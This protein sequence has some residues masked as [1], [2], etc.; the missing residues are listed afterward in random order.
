[1]TLWIFCLAAHS[2]FSS[3]PAIEPA[4]GAGGERLGQPLI[5]LLVKAKSNR[6]ERAT[7]VG[8]LPGATDGSGRVPCTS[9]GAPSEQGADG[10]GGWEAAEPPPETP[11]TDPPSFNLKD[12]AHPFT[13]GR[14][15]ATAFI[16]GFRSS[17][18]R[19]CRSSVA[20]DSSTIAMSMARHKPWGRQI[21]A[22]ISAVPGSITSLNRVTASNDIAL[23]RTARPQRGGAKGC[24]CGYLE[25]KA[26]DKPG[27]PP[28]IK[29]AFSCG[30][31]AP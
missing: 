6:E 3:R 9:A 29:S 30:G 16:N 21:E 26:T 15:R 14:A 8:S 13:N 4:A 27:S 19:P 17:P 5:V 10:R 25:P 22:K 20:I 11:P 28:L 12:V 23:F 31:A 1:M 18:S 2:F 24:R 7:A